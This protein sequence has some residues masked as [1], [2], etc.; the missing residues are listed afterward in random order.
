MDKG[1]L[2]LLSLLVV[3]NV[4]AQ[5]QD[6]EVARVSGN[7]AAVVTPDERSI[8]S[9][10]D[11]SRLEAVFAKAR[12]GEVIS[13]GVIGGS[14]TAGAK[15]ST[16][17]MRYGSLVSQW[18][19]T[20]FPATK[21]RFVNA[22][23]GATGSNYAALRAQRDLL[24][25]TPDFVV[26]E[27]A[28]NESNTEPSAETLEG[29]LRQILK[30][31]NQPAVVLLFMMNDGGGSAQEWHARVGDHYALPMV[32]YRD[33][34]WPE[35]EAGR[36]KWSEISPDM[37]HPN[38]RGHA[39][40][41]G[42]I[43]RLLQRVLDRQVDGVSPAPVL[44]APL[45]SDLYEFTELR[46]DEALKPVANNGWTYDAVSKSWK[47]DFPGASIDFEISGQELFASY[48]VLKSPEARAHVSIDGGPAIAIE[49]TRRIGGTTMI[50]KALPHGQHR[51]HFELPSDWGKDNAGNEFSIMGLGAASGR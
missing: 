15:A 29:L 50:A 49:N 18:W 20:H 32:S 42:Y 41:A 19:R 33:A 30:Q 47:A 28:V 5:V 16:N 34:L 44:P 31:E 26:V 9:M 14:I 25:H 22:G 36:L 6:G 45:L 10:G 1:F 12:R 48:Y 21:V 37:V 4:C 8:V 51:V 2:W 39:L 38:D 13:V 3:N 24:S 27:F 35:I 11:V 40:V 46:E 43:N 7:T 23:R 17:S